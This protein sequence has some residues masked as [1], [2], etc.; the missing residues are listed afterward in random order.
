[1][2]FAALLIA[3][4]SSPV[5]VSYNEFIKLRTCCLFFTDQ[6]QGQDITAPGKCRT[7]CIICIHMWLN[8][9]HSSMLY[10]LVDVFVLLA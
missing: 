9:V 2:Y 10:V 1:M 3:L 7:M 4:V 8:Y 5:V 6:V